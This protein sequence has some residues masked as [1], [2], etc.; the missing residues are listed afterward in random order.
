METNNSVQQERWKVLTRDLVSASKRKGCVHSKGKPIYG[1]F[2]ASSYCWPRASF[3]SAK[4]VLINPPT[5]LSCPIKGELVIHTH[6]EGTDREA[7]RE[8]KAGKRLARRL[9]YSHC[10]KPSS[11]Y[12][13]RKEKKSS[14]PRSSAWRRPGK[15]ARGSQSLPHGGVEHGRHRWLKTLIIFSLTLSLSSFMHAWPARESLR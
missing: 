3:I 8:S 9:H 13:Q 5:A 11:T 12:K 2:A 4:E 14:P 1:D 15:S 10:R 7:D 6:G